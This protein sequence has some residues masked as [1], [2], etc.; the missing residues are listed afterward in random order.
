[1][2]SNIVVIFVIDGIADE[3]ICTAERHKQCHAYLFKQLREKKPKK[4]VVVFF[5]IFRSI[6]VIM[7]RVTNIVSIINIITF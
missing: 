6:F 1:M 7:M 4:I 2:F 3:I 5:N